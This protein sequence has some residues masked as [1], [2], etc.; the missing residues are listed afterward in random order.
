MPPTS[1]RGWLA[2]ASPSHLAGFVYKN[3]TKIRNDPV[4][5]YAAP[6]QLQ[7]PRMAMM[8]GMSG[9]GANANA[10]AST[11][12]NNSASNGPSGPPPFKPMVMVL[13]D[14]ELRYSSLGTVVP[15]R[16]HSGYRLPVRRQL[17][18]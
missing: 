3:D 7:G 2:F 6:H 1:C 10:N 15:H 16:H 11:S 5:S 4:P 17:R 14:N 8:A 18:V 12:N 9:G 13:A